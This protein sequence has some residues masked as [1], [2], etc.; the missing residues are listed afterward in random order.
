MALSNWD[1][2]AFGTDGKPCNAVLQF[3]ERSLSIRKNWLVLEFDK[4]R[5][6]SIHS[7]EIDGFGFNIN[8]IRHT[9]QSSIFVYASAGKYGNEP[10]QYMCGVGCYGFMDEIDWIRKNHPDALNRI[11]QKYLDDDEYM[12]MSS[13]GHDDNRPHY[14]FCGK[15]DHLDVILEC[16]E[17]QLDDLWT[18][19]LPATLQ[20]FGAWLKTVADE[21]YLAKID[22]D[23]ALRFN[24][25]DA[26]FAEALKR[27]ELMQPTPVGQSAGPL[28]GKI[29]S[30]ETKKGEQ[31]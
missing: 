13:C 21:D 30:G 17:P 25:G 2:L 12:R 26:Y 18:G 14:T 22:I 5:H 11:D 9:A 1:C 16:P 27:D 6:M 4:G 19:V 7:G 8:A 31:S 24:Q 15:G 23:N 29:V 3:G 10:P 28:I 20:A